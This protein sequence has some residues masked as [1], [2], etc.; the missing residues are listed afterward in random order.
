MA[1]WII[2]LIIVGVLLLI[3]LGIYNSLVR[4]RNRVK[5]SWSQIDVQL[6]KRYDLVPNLIETVK[7][8]MKHEKE[9][10]TK[11]TQLRSQAMSATDMSMKVKANN[12]LTKALSGLN[13]AVENYPDLKASQNFLMLQEELAGIENK[14][15][16]ARQF[17]N[18]SVMLYNNKIEMFP[19]NIFANMFNFKKEI[20]FEAPEIERQN[21]KVSF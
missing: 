14:I 10:F 9:T 3:V 4:L 21:V 1:T 12:E 2:I 15:A 5:N 20:F 13:I 11:I 8:Y 19:S 6:K 17:Y 16:Y 18:D 7:G